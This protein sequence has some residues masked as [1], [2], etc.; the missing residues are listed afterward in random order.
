MKLPPPSL[1][2]PAIP[3]ML[4]YNL[5]LPPSHQPEGKMSSA[6]PTSLNINSYH[7]KCENLAVVVASKLYGKTR[8]SYQRLFRRHKADVRVLPTNIVCLPPLTA[9]SKL[10]FP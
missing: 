6:Y 8:S 10:A 9:L 2:F 4:I 7:Q 1:Q 3:Q 5:K